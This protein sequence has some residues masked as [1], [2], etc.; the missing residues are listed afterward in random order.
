VRHG[1]LTCGPGST[2]VGDSGIDTQGGAL[3]IDLSIDP[4]RAQQSGAVF[5]QWSLAVIALQATLDGTLDCGGRELR[6]S[7]ANG[8]WGIPG[9]S[10]M[11]VLSTGT[12]TG[13]L[14]A[15]ATGPGTIAGTFDYHSSGSSS[16][17]SICLGTY[18]A[19]LGAD[20]G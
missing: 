18:T 12:L 15:V 8:T 16:G 1:T 10:P 9:P 11:T 4:T 7:F 5:G 2:T 20:G 19:A 13:S 17:D 6:A 14:T 3:S